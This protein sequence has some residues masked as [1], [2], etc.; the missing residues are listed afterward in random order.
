MDFPH[1]HLPRLIARTLS[2]ISGKG[3]RHSVVTTS[4][5]VSQDTA[6]AISLLADGSKLTPGEI[7]DAAIEY[8]VK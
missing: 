8:Y 6:S 5:T 3:F 2:L 4:Y 7:I 1:W